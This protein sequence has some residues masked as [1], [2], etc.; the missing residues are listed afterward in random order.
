LHIGKRPSAPAQGLNRGMP[1]NP[2]GNAFEKSSGV[3]VRVASSKQ[4]TRAM[5]LPGDIFSLC[6]KA[7]PGVSRVRRTR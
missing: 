3:S 1:K 7:N 4:L 2:L 5:V 6:R